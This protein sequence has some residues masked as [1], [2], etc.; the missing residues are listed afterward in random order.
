MRVAGRT[1]G[2]GPSGRWRSDQPVTVEI[3]RW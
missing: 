3:G 2:D 1:A